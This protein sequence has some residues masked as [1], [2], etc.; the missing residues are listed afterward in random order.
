MAGAIQKAQSRQTRQPVNVADIESIDISGAGTYLI[1]LS[2]VAE[3]VSFQQTGNLVGTIAF[4]ITG[5]NFAG[6]TA[7]L[8]AS[9]IGTY[10][11]SMC[12]V[13]QITVASGSGR[14]VIAAK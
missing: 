10:T 7:L 3:K 5:A 2:V 14:I 8:A 13:V 9:A 12:K 11:T 1:N 6:S 4:S